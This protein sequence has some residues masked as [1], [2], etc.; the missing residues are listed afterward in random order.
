M[1]LERERD[2]TESMKFGGLKVDII[3]IFKMPSR[4]ID[5][6]P[7]PFFECTKRCESVRGFSQNNASSKPSLILIL[8]LF[9][10]SIGS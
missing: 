10:M 1:K 4:G 2:S 6:F 5:F 8:K 9:P 3:L 7:E